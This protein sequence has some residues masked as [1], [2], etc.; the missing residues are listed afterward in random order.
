M[1]QPV[2]LN[3]PLNALVT[4]T[5]GELYPLVLAQMRE[6]A[7]VLLDPKG[8]VLW[9]N[10]SAEELFG[11]KLEALVGKR[12]DLLFTPEDA[13]RGVFEHEMATASAQSS[14][15]NDR[16]MKRADGSRF[17]ANGV[18]FP[19]RSASGELAGFCKMLRDRT[20]LRQQLNTL[21][22]EVHALVERGQEKDKILAVAAHEL[23][24]PLFATTVAVDTL[25]R[26]VQNAPEQPFQ[27]IE[28]QLQTMRRLLDDITDAAQASTGKLKLKRER[29]DLREVILRALETMRPA[30]Q[31][32]RHIVNEMLLPVPIPVSGDPGRLEQ[33]LRNI[34]DNSVKYTAPGGVIGIEATIEGTDA[35]VKI[36]DNGVGVAPEMQMEIFDLFTQAAAPDNVDDKGLGIGLSLVKNLVVHHGGTVQ[37]RS[38]GRGKGS[39]FTVR[40]PL[41]S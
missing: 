3:T 26:V 27:V 38:N 16:W 24:N 41:A 30:I 28:R 17:W 15:E 21:Q 10:A 7:V 39:E 32:R 37:V 22:N 6:Y 1:A 5:V 23:R 33:V 25:R 13:A 2:Q 12:G 4:T 8:V 18:M 20:D 31:A 29:L 40:L 34:I 19:L 14:M 36:E 35:V 9:L 11:H